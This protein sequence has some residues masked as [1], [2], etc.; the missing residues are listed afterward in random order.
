MIENKSPTDWLKR[1]ALWSVVFAVGV[2][3][4]LGN[5]WLGGKLLR[6]YRPQLVNDRSVD[7]GAVTFTISATID[8]ADRFVFTR[9]S[10]TN[11]HMSWS[12]PRNVIFDEQPW[13]DLS[14]TAPGWLEMSSNLD[15]GKATIL[16]R[17]S[18]DVIT[19]EH[20]AE[21][22][23]LFFADTAMGAGK[24]EVKIRIPRK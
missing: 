15:L 3:V 14:Q 16:D 11:K 23:D 24:Y 19:L 4:G 17:Q 6:K 12:P 13:V 18:R 7:H 22:F 9:D 20:T 10:V 8:G 2:L 21:G 1:I 5:A